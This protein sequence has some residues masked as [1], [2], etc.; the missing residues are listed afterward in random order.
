[1]CLHPDEI[2]IREIDDI[3]LSEYNYGQE[4]SISC[5]VETCIKDVIIQIFKDDQLL[6]SD[7]SPEGN[8]LVS[9]VQLKV[10]ERL[11]GRYACQAMSEKESFAFK[12]EYF[13]ITGT[14]RIIHCLGF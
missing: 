3:D 1:M 4:L 11:V 13:T 6:E 12:R 2:G 7:T 5:L 10:S 8:K 9:S 14:D